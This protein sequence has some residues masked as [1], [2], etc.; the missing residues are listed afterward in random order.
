MLDVPNGAKGKLEIRLYGY[1]D[2]ESR[3]GSVHIIA[4]R[5]EGV[6]GDD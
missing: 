1:T 4:A 5:V 2:G 6:F 3:A